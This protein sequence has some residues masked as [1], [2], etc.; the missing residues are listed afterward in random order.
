M[1]VMLFIKIEYSDSATVDKIRFTK[2]IMLVP[3]SSPC[4]PS[5]RFAPLIQKRTAR[6]VKKKL[7]IGKLWSKLL[8]I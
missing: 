3:R 1:I 6:I 2:I 7:I 5:I 8:S 4:C